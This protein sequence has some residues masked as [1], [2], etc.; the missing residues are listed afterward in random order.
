M[1]NGGTYGNAAGHTNLRAGWNRATI[2]AGTKIGM[3]LNFNQDGTA[4][5]T[6]YKDGV[7][8]GVLSSG[9]LRGPL[10]PAVWLYEKDQS[11]E[12]VSS[13]LSKS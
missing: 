1:H 13:N 8:A 5:V 11:V 9:S 2:V 3:M 4:T 10:C 12:F 6:A 7:R